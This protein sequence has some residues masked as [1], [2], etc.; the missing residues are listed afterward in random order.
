[1]AQEFLVL[2]PFCLD[3]EGFVVTSVATGVGS[4]GVVLGSGI[5]FHNLG[6]V[7]QRLV[8]CPMVV[9]SS[10]GYG[11]EVGKGVLG[12]SYSWFLVW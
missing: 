1:M 8:G 6:K 3:E 4:N 7:G 10:H 2:R 11:N 5:R 9:K 12:I